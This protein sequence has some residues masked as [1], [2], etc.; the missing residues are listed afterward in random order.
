MNLN[1]PRFGGAGC[2][3]LE[4]AHKPEGAFGVCQYLGDSAASGQR[5]S[6][7]WWRAHSTAMYRVLMPMRTLRKP[8]SRCLTL[9]VALGLLA[10]CE[11]DS[12]TCPLLPD[13]T[14]LTVQLSAVPSGPY[15]VEAVMPTSWPVT[16]VYRCDGGLGCRSTRV[17]F[18]GLVAP[19]GTTVRVTTSLGTRATTFQRIAY[20]DAYPNGSSCEPRSTTATVSAAIP[21]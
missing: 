5:L 3:A 1:L 6:M 17:F 4:S 19:Y 20:T 11:G 7:L 16:Y 15:T 13:N 9:C 8:A 2:G 18:P 21:E 14:G 12:V 10:A